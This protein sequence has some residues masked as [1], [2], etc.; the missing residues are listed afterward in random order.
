MLV[1]L[2]SSPDGRGRQYLKKKMKKKK[3]LKGGHDGE[4]SQE[5]P[6]KE[7]IFKL[8]PAGHGGSHL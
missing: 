6:A 5:G 3:R 8:R 2:H 1:P 4:G 7:V